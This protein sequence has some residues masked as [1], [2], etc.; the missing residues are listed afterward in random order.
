MACGKKE[1]EAKPPS[2]PIVGVGELPVS[3]RLTATAPPDAHE[4]EISPSEIHVGSQ[5]LITLAGGNVAAADRQGSE[6]P[7]LTAALKSPVRARASFAI[8]SEVPYETVALAISSAKAAGLRG[9]AFKVRAPNSMS[10]TGFIALDDFSV[11]PRTKIDEEVALSG[12]VAR[13]WEEFTAHWEDI[14]NACR[15]AQTG[16]CA[17][18]PE[19]IATG[20]HL[21]IA[22]LAAGQGV[23]VN[24]SQVGAPPPAEAPKKP[25]VEMLDGV[26]KTDIVKDVEE[27]PPA[28]DA[29]FQFRAQ[30]ALKVPS[31]VSEVMKP[32][33]G[34]TAC[35]VVLN[36]EKNTMFV[37]VAS[38]LGAAFPDNTPAPIVQFELP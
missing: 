16:S 14:G 38:L 32:I 35:G 17:Y 29:S 5:P 6:I 22:L 24:F 18:K 33:C 25:K 19:K 7:K 34:T 11:G 3:L 1:E 31:P 27:A 26:K 15:G 30:E 12:V 4:V 2:G 37:R 9:I 13:P 8:S 23:N 10:T 36:G 21:K 28:T 20:G